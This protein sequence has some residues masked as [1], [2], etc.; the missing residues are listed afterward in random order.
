MAEIHRMFRAG[1]GEGRALVDGVA[2]GDAA[3]ADVVGDHLAMLSIGLHAHHEGED[4]MLWARS[5]SAPR[6]AP[7]TS[8]A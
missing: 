2:E 4:T 8:S 5:S 1:F 3:H 6:R 7:C